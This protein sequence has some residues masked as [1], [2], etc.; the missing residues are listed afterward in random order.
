[1]GAIAVGLAGYAIWRFVQAGE[2]TENK[3]TD[4]QGL[5]TRVG[6]A[7]IGTL[8][9]AT[10]WFALQLALGSAGESG[11][12]T[13]DMTATLMAKPLGQW[14]V[15]LVG[16]VVLG[17]ALYQMYLAYSARFTECLKRE[18]MTHEQYQAA[19][20]AGRLGYGARSVA[21]TLIGGFLIV[22]AWRAQPDE[23]RGLG[24]ALAALAE[25]PFG[26]SLLLVVALGLIAYG[27][28]MVIQARFRR[29][30]V[31]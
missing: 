1:M 9:L 24:G 18:E 13:H 7:V 21:F 14:L 25:Q 26:P 3:G 10:A 29:M 16:A 23:A 22:A 19:S 20:W 12:A 27:A 6:Y 28:F 5:I 31:R 30:V 8:Y 11:D 2:D 17:S 4:A 15:G